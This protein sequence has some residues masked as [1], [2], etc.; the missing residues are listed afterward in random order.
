MRN[1][2]RGFTLIELLVVIGI[3]A[4]LIAL[5]LPAMRN[6]RRAA[7]HTQ[8]LAGLRE[9]LAG[10]TQYHI[11]NKGSVL[12]GYTPATVNGVPITATD[13][14]S[15]QTF[16]LPVADRYPWRLAPYVGNVWGILHLHEQTPPRPQ[17]T[18]APME[19][20]LKAYLLS[21]NPSFGI[22]SIYVG[23]HAG[24]LF[25]GFAGTTGD[26]PNVGKH[27]V[28]KANHVRRS[29]Q[30]IVFA[31]C[32]SRNAPFGDPEAGMHFA[33]PPRANGQRW[34][35]VN[36]EIQVLTGVISGIPKSR[37]SKRTAVGFFDGHAESLPPKELEDMRLWAN[38]AT[39]PTYDFV[40]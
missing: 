34:T 23:G 20:L 30:L 14:F 21:I 25:Q 9:L 17:A 24:P 1:T 36:D 26:G 7:K 6:A 5:L 29:S 13:P 38:W 19:A 22:N 32:Q 31:E 35:V 8:M 11:A 15:G 33:M 3:I 12:F 4:L 27:V 40:P 10:Y 39:G 2:R 16:G 18:D 28:F 37:F